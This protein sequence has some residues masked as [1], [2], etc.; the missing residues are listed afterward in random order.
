MVDL[1]RGDVQD[2]RW[3]AVV[4]I[5][6][7]KRAKSRL[8][9]ELEPWRA[10]LAVAF[11]ADTL[12]ALVAAE[13][14]DLV[15]VVGGDGLPAAVLGQPGIRTLPDPGDLN[16][17]ARHGIAWVRRHRP[18]SAI[19]VL[20][21]DL[22]SATPAAIDRLLAA[23]PPSPLRVIPDEE[24]LGSTGLLIAPRAGVL[25][26][27]ALRLLPV[28]RDAVEAMLDETRLGLLLAG[29]RGAAPADRPALV[30]AVLALSDAVVGWPDGFE[31]DLNPVTVL[32]EGRGVRVL[33]AAYVAPKE[34]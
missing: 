26:D 1:Y 32:A 23:A 5:K 10:E 17:A 21:A 27:V 20:A 6:E 25:D 29:V 12:T 7:P 31:L 19:L 24:Q 13:R 14:I 28:D 22:P 4:P 30:D 11:A 18:D 2:T 9:P 34:Q 3:S 33:D 16:A 15:V 8:S